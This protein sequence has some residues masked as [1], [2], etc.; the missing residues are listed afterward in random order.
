MKT[1]GLALEIDSRPARDLIVAPERTA[2]GNVAL[3]IGREHM[4]AIG[5]EQI[6]YV[7]LTSD[8]AAQLGRL[9]VK[10]GTV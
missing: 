4:D 3:R 8:E 9:L 6:A 2:S 5:W 1:Y 10:A 7:V